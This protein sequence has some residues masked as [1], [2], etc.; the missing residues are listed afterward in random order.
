MTND[1]NNHDSL[2]SVS[3]YPRPFIASI[4]MTIDFSFQI[5][6]TGSLER[7]VMRNISFSAQN[8]QNIQKCKSS[9]V[10]LSQ[11]RRGNV[12]QCF[13]ERETSLEGPLIYRAIG[14]R[15]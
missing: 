13:A 2:S 11:I 9:I 14:M 8:I 1:I 15:A 10:I 5:P 7:T 6:S 4:I 3:H 12:F